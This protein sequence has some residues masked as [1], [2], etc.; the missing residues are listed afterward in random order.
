MANLFEGSEKKFR[1]TLSLPSIFISLIPPK[2]SLIYLYF[3]E[4]NF[5]RSDPF[6]AKNFLTIE[7]IVIYERLRT[8]LIISARTGLMIINKT[9]MDREIIELEII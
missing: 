9:I 2:V 5:A 3:K 6:L 4:L 7:K 8:I 1:N